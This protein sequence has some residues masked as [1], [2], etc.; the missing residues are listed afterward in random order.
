MVTTEFPTPEYPG[1]GIFIARQ[2]DS[3]RAGGITVDVL[4]F[5]SGAS[6]K[7]HYRAWRRMR[8]MMA[9]REYDLIHAQ[10]GHAALISR[11][12]RTLPVV[13]TYRGG[14][15]QGIVGPRGQ[16]TIKGFF[17][18]GLCQLL[19][20]TVDEV[21]VVSERLGRIVFRRDH[22]VIPSGLDLEL[23]QPLPRDEARERIGWGQGHPIVLFAAQNIEFPNK[24]YALARAAVDLV[25][26]EIENVELRVATRVSPKQ[27]PWVVNAADVLLLTSIQ[28]GSPNVVKEALA[29]NLPVVT[30]DVGDVRERLK[31]VDKG[32]VC[33]DTAQALAAALLPL[34]RNPTR[35]DS[36]RL[37]NGLSEESI[38]RRVIRVYQRMVPQPGK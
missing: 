32:A 9:D 35:A 28:E 5:V 23:F 1:N 19:S 31:E 7:S 14:G 18:V 27:M 29:C 11:L 3:L 22:H 24:R 20:L 13:V 25:A 33:D 36:R 30:V 38:A 6:P 8:R 10:F 37:V 17:L 26:R 4:H 21:I 15:L 2:A 12:Q 34:L 16:K